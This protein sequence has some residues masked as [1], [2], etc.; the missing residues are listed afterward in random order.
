[1]AH[2]GAEALEPNPG[3]EELKQAMMTSKL[4]YVS[5][6]EASHNDIKAG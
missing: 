6:G 4:D 3:D 1:M 2:D 5:Q